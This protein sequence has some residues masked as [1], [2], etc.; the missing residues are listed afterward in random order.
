MMPS[1]ALEMRLLS[2]LDEVNIQAWQVSADPSEVTT[3]LEFL[4]AV[5]ESEAVPCTPRYVEFYRAG[6]LV[7]G[8]AAYAVENDLLGY[9]PDRL[10]RWLG[11]FRRWRPG[12]LRLTT[13]EIGSPLANGT[14]AVVAAQAEEADLQAALQL[15]QRY[16]RQQGHSLLLLRD[17]TGPLQPLE[18]AAVRAGW[19]VMPGYPLAEMRLVWGSFADYVAAM[20]KH[21][22]YDLRE[23]MQRKEKAAIR[24]VVTNQPD[25]L[26]LVEAYA[27]LYRNVLERS[28]EYPREVIG[29]AYHRAMR[30]HLGER[31]YWLQYFQDGRLCAFAHLIVQGEALHIQY[32]GMDYQVSRQAALYFNIIY[33]SIRLAF[34]Q[35]LRVVKGG[36]TTYSV[37][38]AIGF[39]I[40]PQRMYL[41]HPN[42]LVRRLAKSF[43]A[44]TADFEQAQYRV[45]FRDAG[46]QV[47]WDGRTLDQYY[48][49]PQ[50]PHRPG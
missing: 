7:L 36:V 34:E 38:S 29:V 17:F 37:K 50:M 3:N 5:A 1:P 14:P 19:Q 30:R 22:R 13:M 8:F 12:W 21:Y 20:R 27:A 15:F 39:S 26:E 18:R 44:A 45:P 25:A 47:I 24:T 43:F 16:C 49:T 31:S 46:L 2:S 10:G 6:Q 41:W 11:V 9:L 28:E 48:P 23:K 32:L 33:D 35:G 4:R 40:L 42:P